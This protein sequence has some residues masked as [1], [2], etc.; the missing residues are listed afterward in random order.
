MATLRAE[1]R[2]L[3]AGLNPPSWRWTVCSNVGGVE[4]VIAWDHTPDVTEAFEAASANLRSY[5][6]S[7]KQR[8]L[9]TNQEEVNAMIPTAE[10]L[11]QHAQAAFEDAC[12]EDASPYE[13]GKAWQKVGEHLAAVIAEAAS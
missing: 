2:E 11:A 12:P 8:G 13:V 6:T 9:R 10:Q 3:S 5:L 4:H 7:E 1:V